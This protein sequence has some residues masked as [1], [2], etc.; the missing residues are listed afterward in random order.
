MNFNHYINH[1]ESLDRES[2]YELRRYVALYPCHQVARLLLIHNLFL[3]HDH[4]FDDELHTAAFYITDRSTLF[5]M[6]ESQYAPRSVADK[7]V[8]VLDAKDAEMLIDNFLTNIPHESSPS[9]HKPTILDATTDYMAYI[10]SEAADGGKAEGES[11]SSSKNLIDSFLEQDGGKLTISSS[12]QSED[13][14]P[15]SAVLLENDRD[16]LQEGFYTE[17]LAKVYVKQGNYSKALEII[18]QLNLNNSEKNTY[19][20]DQMRFLEKVIAAKRNK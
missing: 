9:D 15:H 10:M 7:E 14:A 20:T 16:D 1:P 19:F 3:L 18:K 11:S 17:S 6:I 8:S 4:S 12:P 13:D 2:L 5:N